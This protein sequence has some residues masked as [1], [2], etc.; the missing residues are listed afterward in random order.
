MTATVTSTPTTAPTLP[1]SST[2]LYVGAAKRDITPMNAVFLGG[3]GFG[4]GRKSTGVLAPIHVR[5]FVVSDGTHAIA[6]AE[7]ETQGTFAAYKRGPWG[8]T[9][10]RLAIQDATHG[11]LPAQN[12]VI[13]SD[14][15]HSGPD[16]TGVWGGLPNA[17]MTML[18]DLTLEA[19]VEAFNTMRPAQLLIGS[20]DARELLHSQFDAP[21]NDFV[22][23]E[24]RVLVAADPGDASKI[25]TIMINFSAHADV[26][27]A[28]N[29]LL[30]SDWP[31]V[32]AGKMEQSL[33]IDNA[34]VMVADVGRT[35]PSGGDGS[36]DPERLDS[37]ANLIKAKVDT[38]MSALTPVN[39]T[40]VAA[41]ELF[42][43]DPFGNQVIPFYYLDGIISRNDKPPWVQGSNIGTFASAM[44]IGDVLLTAVPGEGY[45]SIRVG[46]MQSV[47][48]QMHFIFGLAN[49]QLGYLIAPQE[50]YPQ[51]LAASPGNDNAL[52]NVSPAI[53]DHVMCTLFKGVQRINFVT[54]TVPDK[55]S[56]WADEDN[57]L[58]F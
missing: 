7:N 31:G 17:Y 13:G 43:S 11:A 12:I 36:T 30:S 52:F 42:L 41:T 19:V 5:A 53:G 29:K 48:A 51:V 37:Y 10:T 58:P 50:G 21:P 27:G 54:P 38:A 2:G 34:L 35:Q 47:T 46:L 32:V 25:Q 40:Q 4:P 23:S 24:L 9:E 56:V 18:R 22:D 15:S 39:G 57:S 26:M 14:H 20:T 6:F 16:T 55:C 3:F 49:D 28:D 1:P 44:R 33:G 8:L 45:P